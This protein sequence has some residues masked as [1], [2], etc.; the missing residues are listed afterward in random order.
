M[1]LVKFGLTNRARS[2]VSGC[3]R[4]T[5]CTERMSF[6]WN[7]FCSSFDISPR[8]EVQHVLVDGVQPVE[9]VADRL[10][11]PLVGDDQVDPLGVAAVRRDDHAPQDRA[12]GRVGDEGD[13]G[14]PAALD[15][16]PV[17]AGVL[18]V[19]EQQDLGMIGKGGGQGRVGRSHLAEAAA[20]GD[21]L[22]LGDVLV[23]EEDHLP[24]QQGRPDLGD[25]V[26]VERGRTDR[27]RRSRHRC[28]R[29]SDGCRAVRPPAVI[30]VARW[31]GSCAASWILGGD[32][33]WVAAQVDV[34]L[35]P[36]GVRHRCRRPAPRRCRRD[37]PGRWPGPRAGRPGR[38]G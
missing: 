9:Q 19:V 7:I 32:W 25:D 3:T 18:L 34:D 1:W 13:V 29:T 16:G 28:I 23:P 12:H 11:Q 38:A 14:V 27:P 10:R 15:L 21:V 36:G 35:G 5:G 33:S 30:G 2:P 4:T 17:D 20:E 8:D 22:G 26:G 24:L 37:R 31:S 6:D